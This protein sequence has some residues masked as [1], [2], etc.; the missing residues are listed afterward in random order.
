MRVFG[1]RPTCRPDG[2][3][4]S[5][6]RP[7]LLPQPPP[8]VSFGLAPQLGSGRQTPTW[9][10]VRAGLAVSCGRLQTVG[11]AQGGGFENCGPQ[12][13]AGKNRTGPP[14]PLPPLPPHTPPDAD[15]P[16]GADARRP[17]SEA[18]DT[19]SLG[20]QR[21]PTEE[22]RGD[23]EWPR[24]EG[25]ER[26]GDWAG[27]PGRAGATGRP[28]ASRA[29]GGAHLNDTPSLTREGGHG[30]LTEVGGSAVGAVPSP[31]GSPLCPAWAP[32]DGR[33]PALPCLQPHTAGP[34]GLVPQG[35]HL[36]AGYF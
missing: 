2:I 30:A 9:G 17:A 6:P 4:P 13:L 33:S 32:W 15:P 19:R 10:G 21:P 5:V 29:G 23:E 22:S 31:G 36:F 11:P 26:G 28:G 20:T 27:G 14:P 24:P 1:D 8:R 18:E 7:R 35:L 16:P 34:R 25:P 12:Q 3:P